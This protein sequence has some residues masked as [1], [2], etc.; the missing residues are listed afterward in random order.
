MGHLVRNLRFGGLAL[1]REPR[2]HAARLVGEDQSIQVEFIG[3]V[4]EIRWS[5][6]FGDMGHLTL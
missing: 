4:G 2:P 3:W 5:H 6:D 1:L